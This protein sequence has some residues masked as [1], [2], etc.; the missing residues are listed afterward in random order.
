M[1]R[2]AL[3]LLAVVAIVIFAAVSIV[4]LDKQRL[5]RAQR[6]E[7]FASEV[8]LG[9]MIEH[10]RRYACRSWGECPGGSPLI[11]ASAFGQ[12]CSAS[13]VQAA[14]EFASYSERMNGVSVPV[15]V[16][17]GGT[18]ILSYNIFMPKNTEIV[19]EK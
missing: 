7:I 19:G 9:K 5:E 15:R 1:T 17:F 2:I 8:A 18:C 12:V 6:A 4:R 3:P 14:M 13:V 11:A 10:E 16:D